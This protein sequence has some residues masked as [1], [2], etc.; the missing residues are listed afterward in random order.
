MAATLSH[1]CFSPAITCLKLNPELKPINSLLCP[2]SYKPISSSNTNPR[3]RIYQ[4]KAVLHR[5]SHRLFVVSGLVDGNSE[6]YPEAESSDLNEDGA[7]IDIKLP[8]RSLLVQ[9]TCNECG[10][11][12]KRL[13]NRLAY[14]RGLVYVQ[15]PNLSQEHI[16]SLVLELNATACMSSLSSFWIVVCPVM[17]LYARAVS[18]DSVVTVGGAGG[19]GGFGAGAGAGAGEGTNDGDGAGGGIAGAG[20]GAGGGVAGAGAGVAGA[21]AGTSLAGDGAGVSF[22]GAGAGG[23]C[24]GA[25]DTCGGGKEG[26]GVAGGG[27]SAGGCIGAAVGGGTIGLVAGATLGDGGGIGVV[28]GGGVAALIGDCIGVVGVVEGGG[29][30]VTGAG[31]VGKVVDGDAAGV[32][33]LVIGNGKL[34]QTK[35]R[36]QSTEAI[37]L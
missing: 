19:L 28:A 18:S 8:R 23:A 7:T 4:T 21:G 16:V 9:F 24:A 6:T 26:G 13:I 15:A 5:R 1:C 27:G 31:V 36:T 35:I 20:T 17:M 34:R 2:N 37:L 14:E 12:S 3:L 33:A 22:A 32:W 10:E 25:G 11:R 30:V 29:V